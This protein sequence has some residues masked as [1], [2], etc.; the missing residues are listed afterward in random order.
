MIEQFRVTKHNG[1]DPYYPVRFTAVL[2]EKKPLK[3]LVKEV[4]K[5]I[6]NWKAPWGKVFEIYCDNPAYIP[7]NYVKTDEKR[8]VAAFVL[9]QER[10]LIAILQGPA[11]AWDEAI[12]AI[13]L[14]GDVVRGW[15]IEHGSGYHGPDGDAF[16]NHYRFVLTELKAGVLRYTAMT[17]TDRRKND[18]GV[19][20]SKIQ[21]TPKEIDLLAEIP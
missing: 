15:R 14:E 18:Q 16:G 1:E 8:G 6:C 11:R 13:R 12:Y 4:V 7:Y 9:L 10:P 17:K 21:D 20:T 2:P 3:A 19:W 5:A